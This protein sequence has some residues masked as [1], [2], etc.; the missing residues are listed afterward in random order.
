MARKSTK[1]HA[2]ARTSKPKKERLLTRRE[3]AAALHVHMQTITKWEREGLPI[4]ERGDKGRPSKYREI[5]VR[6]WR[7]TREEAA[8]KKT[9]GGPVDFMQARA[10]KEYWQGKVAEQQ[11]QI[12]ARELL[13]ASEVEKVWGAECAAIRTVILSIPVTYADRVHRAATLEGLSGVEAALKDIAHQVLRELEREDR[14]VPG[15]A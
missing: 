13:Q 12:R 2:R 4:A 8:K 11:H 9:E 5:D 7:K 1:A 14:P 10:N 3:L 6:A 15:V